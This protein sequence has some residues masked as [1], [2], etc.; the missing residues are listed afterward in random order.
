MVRVKNVIVA[1][2]CVKLLSSFSH[3]GLV[4]VTAFVAVWLFNSHYHHD[5]VGMVTAATLG[6]GGGEEEEE[7]GRVSA[8]GSRKEG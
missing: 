7:E 8:S 3:F 2:S 6:G 1:A 4:I 5:G